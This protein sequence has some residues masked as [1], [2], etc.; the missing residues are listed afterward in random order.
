ML[1]S[2][3][4][5]QGDAFSDRGSSFLGLTQKITGIIAC[6]IKS[7]VWTGS[8]QARRKIMVVGCFG[9]GREGGVNTAA[10]GDE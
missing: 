3:A 9:D 1:G 6:I 8:D 5:D 2:P 4:Y 10:P 7:D